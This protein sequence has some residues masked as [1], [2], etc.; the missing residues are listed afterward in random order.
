MLQ[1][2]TCVWRCETSR[3]L[4][5]CAFREIGRDWLLK[6]VEDLQHEYVIIRSCYP[7]TPVVERQRSTQAQFQHLGL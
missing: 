6:E 5:E 3:Y 4:D 2:S 7:E 1:S